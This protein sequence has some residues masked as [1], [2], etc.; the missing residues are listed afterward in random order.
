MDTGTRDSQKKTKCHPR[1][2]K[3]GV[4]K[5]ARTSKKKKKNTSEEVKKKLLGQ[6]NFKKVGIGRR[7]LENLTLLGT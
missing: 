4:R 2:G 5:V 6:Q 1:R 3:K 7:R